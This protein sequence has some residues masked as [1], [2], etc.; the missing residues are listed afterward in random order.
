[1]ERKT[2][3]TAIAANLAITV[4][5]FVLTTALTHARQITGVLGSPSTT[6]TIDGKQLPPPSAQFGGV[7]KQSAL[8][9]TPWWSAIVA[10]PNRAIYH[11][12]WIAGTTPSAPP[13]VKGTAKNG[14][15]A[16]NSD[17]LNELKALFLTEAA[18][19]NVFPMDNSVFARLVTPRPSTTAGRT[20]FTYAGEA[21]GIPPENAPSILDRDYIMTAEL[22]IPK[23]GAEGMIVTMGGRFG[24]YGLY[25]CK[26]F[27]WWHR[28]SLI[29]AGGVALFAVGLLL[30]WRGRTKTW[31]STAMRVGHTLTALG[32]LLFMAVF[33][34]AALGIG[35]GRPVFVYN[36]FDLKS[37]LWQGSAISAGKHTLAFD[38]KYDGPGPGK[39]GTG[40]LSVDGKELSRKTIP[41]T[42]PLV[43]FFETF[44][45]GI[46]TRTRVDK[47][48]DLPFRFTGKLN[49]LSIKVG[50][51]QLLE[52]EQLTETML[53]DSD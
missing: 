39:G 10:P 32:A 1:M 34:T 21:S 37:Y 49:K 53:K 12:G 6:T 18:K 36:L 44:D 29:K 19:F 41:H 50:P 38:F 16:Q 33:T 4:C 20:E 9:S 47:S 35:K 27:N 25:L 45:V 40:V 48:Y 46:D 3:A 17:K 14:L 52:A 26:R 22:T 28:E 7:V 15:S 2:I 5:V 23:G 11:D 42:M 31:S 13:W 30:S 8:D 24:G 51:S 43:T